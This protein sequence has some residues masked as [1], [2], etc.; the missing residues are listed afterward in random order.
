[1]KQALRAWLKTAAR[2]GDHT[3]ACR[4]AAEAV[5]EV[6][7]SVVQDAG[8]LARSA[9]RQAPR[10]LGLT[11]TLQ[12]RPPDHPDA[13]VQVSKGAPYPAQD[14]AGR[15]RRGAYDTPAAMAQSTV[16]LACRA[17]PGPIQSAVDPACGTGAFLVAL[18]EQSVPEISGIEPDPAAIAVARIAVPR[19]QISQADG[20]RPGPSANLV[21][22]NPPFVSSGRQRKDQRAALRKRFPWLSG[23]FDLAVPFAASSVDRAS[24][25][26]VVA[27]VLPASLMVQPYAAALR[28]QW[29]AKHQFHAISTP[30]TFPGAAVKVVTVVLRVDAGPAPL[31]DG[32][33]TAQALLTLDQAPLNPHLLPGDPALVAHLRSLSVRLGDLAE[34]DTGVVS[35]G[36]S[37]GK[38]RLLRDT[39]DAGFVPYVDAKD[40]GDGR[41]RWLS[42]EPDQMHRPKRPE[43][44]EGPKVLVQRLRGRGPVRAWVDR[45]N[46]VAGHTLTVVKPYSLAPE[47]ILELVQ[48]PMIDAL[49]RIE[50]GQRL[51]LYPRDVRDIPVP[52]AWLADPSLSI[53]AAWDLSGAQVAALRRHIC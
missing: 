19:A 53:E 7:W 17:H 33:L 24:S 28:R 46:L 32:G 8:W 1:M 15:R 39:P 27:L 36:P 25:G 23:R 44:F 4:A 51:D 6:P 16:A 45:K 13:I 34:V 3:E 11:R 5:A 47:R 41:T 12:V 52:R 26:G 9:M 10:D 42:Y 49:L 38:E 30:K 14:R 37:G 29:I 48:N 2:H 40:L 22:G 31:P 21:V 18:A 50:R 20:L 43:L 35:H